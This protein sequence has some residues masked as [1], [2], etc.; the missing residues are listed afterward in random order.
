MRMGVC[1]WISDGSEVIHPEPALVK[2]VRLDMSL[3]TAIICHGL[4][5]A[6]PR[7]VRSSRPRSVRHHFCSAAD[8]SDGLDQIRI[9]TS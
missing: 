5:E 8:R 9:S 7:E 2:L 4:Y 6:N 1:Q 3:C